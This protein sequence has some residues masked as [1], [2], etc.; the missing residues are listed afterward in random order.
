MVPR[1]SWRRAGAEA[2]AKGGDASEFWQAQKKWGDKSE[3][4]MTKLGTVYPYIF[5][6]KSLWILP[7]FFFNVYMSKN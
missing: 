1:I 7:L 2:E 4:K 3:S 5:Y 6:V